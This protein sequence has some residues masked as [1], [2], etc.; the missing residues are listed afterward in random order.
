MLDKLVLISCIITFYD[1]PLSSIALQVYESMTDYD[2]RSIR[3]S[4][5]DGDRIHH[6][7]ETAAT[8][9]TT[10]TNHEP[11]YMFSNYSTAEEESPYWEPTDS[12]YEL[13]A[14]LKD[15][16]ISEDIK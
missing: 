3:Y 6:Q 7:G 4:I 11:H 1:N 16:E 8:L 14:Y 15:C 9:Q 5:T 12:D 2:E 13:R 10:I